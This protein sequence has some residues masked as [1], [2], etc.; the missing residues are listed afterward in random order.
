MRKIFI[1]FVII[2]SSNFYLIASEKEKG[3]RYDFSKPHQTFVLPDTLREISGVTEI[4]SQ[5]VACVQDENGILFIYDLQ[6]KKIRS[7]GLFHP[8][9]DYEGI[10]RVGNA[11]YIL[12]SDGLLIEIPNFHFPDKNVKTYITGIPADNNEGLCYDA[13]A[14]RLLIAC[15]SK[16]G[17]GP[18]FKDLRMVYAF[19]LL[20]KKL[21]QNPVFT[22]NMSEIK[23]FVVKNSVSTTVR[24]KKNNSGSEPMIRFR[25]SAIALHPFTNELYLLSAAD[26]MLFVF[27]ANGDILHVEQLDA[28]VYNKA[29]GITFLS[30]GDMLI[31][32]EAQLKRPTLLRLNYE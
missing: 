9:G 25:T 15:K 3:R 19:D 30:N 14:N 11:M 21:Q 32:N 27:N 4:D 24:V 20:T 10:A 18:E 7:Q 28:S 5:T 8:D 31:T 26:H 22:F 17:K 1:A 12:R 16:V 23:S 29:E 2:V 13:S 6:E